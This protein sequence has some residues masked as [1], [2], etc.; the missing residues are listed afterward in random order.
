[1][2]LVTLHLQPGLCYGRLCVEPEPDIPTEPVILEL[3]LFPGAV[4]APGLQEHASISYPASGYLKTA[5]AHF[6]LCA[7][8][9]TAEEWYREAFAQYG[10]HV[11][12]TNRSL[13][14]GVL[15]STGIW[16][17]PTENRKI[18]VVL[19]FH[20]LPGDQL[21]LPR[22]LLDTAGVWA[23][24]VRLANHGAHAIDT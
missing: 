1:M 9:P 23:E 24:I 4:P 22:P 10:Y 14:Q 2:D 17:A 13:Q 15:Q 12:G 3:P 6:T 21:S 18:G 16:F 7:D 8:R 5:T 11:Q 19:S 20:D